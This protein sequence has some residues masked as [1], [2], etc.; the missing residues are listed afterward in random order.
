MLSAITLGAILT[1]V[2]V[3]LDLNWHFDWSGRVGRQT[4]LPGQLPSCKPWQDTY[5]KQVNIRYLI[6]SWSQVNKMSNF[7]LL[8][9]LSKTKKWNTCNNYPRAVLV[10]QYLW[11]YS[12]YVSTDP[13]NEFKQAKNCQKRLYSVLT[14]VLLLTPCFPCDTENILYSGDH[15]PWHMPLDGSESRIQ[16]MLMAED[17]QLLPITTPFGVV[18]FVQIIGVCE[19]ELRAAQHWNGPGVIE[20]I[21]SQS[22]AGGPWLITDMRRGETIFEVEPHLQVN[23]FKNKSVSLLFH[24]YR[25]CIYTTAVMWSILI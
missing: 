3:G 8:L 16:H 21:R 18:N 22:C 2:Q 23:I 7:F 6:T 17:A 12:Q 20:L 5:S 14:L 11:S 1:K 10:L 19:E 24:I 4:P 9:S 15:V 25:Y 13:L